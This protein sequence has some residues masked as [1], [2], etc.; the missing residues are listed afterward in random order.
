MHEHVGGGQ[1]LRH[2][3][4]EAEHAHVPARRKTLGQLAAHFLV[5]SG[6][7]DHRRIGNPFELADG[8]LEIAHPP[9]AAGHDY[10]VP[11]AREAERVARG[12]RVARL[13]KLSG[14][15]RPDDLGA[16][17]TGDPL[18]VRH[19]GLVHDQVRVDA[20]L[21]PEEKTGH[22]GDRRNRRARR[23]CAGVACG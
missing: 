9:A 14:D 15:Q 20:A 23:A 7:A 3:L 19:R 21:G 5:A 1:E 13:E 4:G 11:V 12:G 16:A 6:N 22:V 10:D 17:A 18:D 2:F 8:A